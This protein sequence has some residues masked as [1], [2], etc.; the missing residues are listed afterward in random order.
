LIAGAGVAVDAAERVE[1]AA[2][3]DMWAA[4]D[5]RTREALGL[6]SH[7][8]GDLRVV[9]CAAT[10][11]AEMLNRVMGVGL[12]PWDRRELAA[13]AG[14]LHRHG[15]VAQVSLRD[16]APHAAQA[17]AGLASLGFEPGYAWM[18]FVHPGGEPQEPEEPPTVRVRRCAAAD[19]RA[20]G[21]VVAGGFALPPQFVGFVA[22]LVGRERWSC[23]LAEDAAGA[24]L[25]AAAMFTDGDAAW[26]GLGATL[27]AARRRGA[28]GALLRARTAQA[29]AAGCALV[30]METGAR[31]EGRPSAS[32]RNIL[33]AGFEERGLRPNLVAPAAAG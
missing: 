32:Y 24:P 9:G 26:L 25:G 1:F 31:V 30:T 19:A 4:A 23:L 20:F 29:A 6:V 33:R 3:A 18:R 17:R 22:A 13:A 28:Q 16:D 8:V 12:A 15:C 5:A 27:P 2:Y 14:A 21:E 7:A 10:P 11:G